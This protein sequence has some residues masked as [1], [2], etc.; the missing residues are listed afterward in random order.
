[1]A[2]VHEAFCRATSVVEAE[3]GRLLAYEGGFEEEYVTTRLCLSLLP[4]VRYA[5]FNRQQEG[6]VGSDYL[7][8]W[9]DRTGE[10]F[11]C[12]VQAKSIK[13]QGPHWRIGFQHAGGAQLRKLFATAD[14]FG[15]PAAFTLYAGDGAYRSQM[16]CGSS[17]RGRVPCRDREGAAVT[18]VPALVAEREMRFAQAAPWHPDRSAVEV[19]CQWAKPLVEITA[20]G[21]YGAGGVHHGLRLAGADRDLL[22][23]LST[24]QV[25]ARRIA[26]HIF[27]VAGRM[28]GGQY[29][30]AVASTWTEAAPD[31]A[32]GHLPA[33]T[34]HFTVPYAV[35]I[36]RGLRGRVPQYVER[37]L[38]G[39][40]PPEIADQIDGIVL[41]EV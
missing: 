29:A 33:V 6:R 3:M 19:F 37:C 18:L 12:L 36:L 13:K 34:G 40:V 14:R 20:P 22:Q 25:G 39:D 16:G 38:N 15:V 2:S 11:G 9:V 31:C 28:A 4:E 30:A 21:A 5:K 10:C 24:D 27:D 7:W 41:V 35:H 1:M 8:W 26:R 32:F 17:H 23:F